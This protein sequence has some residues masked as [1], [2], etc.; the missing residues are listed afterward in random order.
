M[1]RSGSRGLRGRRRE[2]H[3]LDQLL[4]GA[5]EGRSRVLV[6]RGEPGIGKT[7]L[8][9]HLASRAEGCRVARATGV[10]LRDGNPPDRFLISLATLSLLSDV[11][12]EQPLVCLVD[13]AQWLDQ[14]SAHTLTFVARR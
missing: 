14:A 10:G 13:D 8:L 11:A 3:A 12:E 1:S 4:T 9:E 7:A 6:L 2:C 5:R